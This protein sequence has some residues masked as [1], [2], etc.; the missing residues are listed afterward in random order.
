MQ[1]RDRTHDQD[2]RREHAL[3]HRL[4][5]ALPDERPQALIEAER[6]EHHQVHRD[7]PRDRALEQ[8]LSNLIDNGCKYGG[9]VSVSL[10]DASSGLVIDFRDRLLCHRSKNGS[11][12]TLA[13]LRVHRPKDGV[14]AHDDL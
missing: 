9:E 7:D 5:F 10:L 1:Q 3:D 8:V 12:G 13:E 4:V 14:F 11:R 6:R 2:G